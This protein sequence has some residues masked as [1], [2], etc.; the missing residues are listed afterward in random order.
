MQI[1]KKLE[2]NF[3][4]FFLSKSKIFKEKFNKNFFHIFKL[5]RGLKYKKI[6]Y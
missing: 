2:K 6:F 1:K 3:S 5:K 4:N